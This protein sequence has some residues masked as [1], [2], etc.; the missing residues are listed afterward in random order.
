MG[1]EGSRKQL[2]LSPI[3]DDVVESEI[4]KVVGESLQR[5]KGWRCE[6]MVALCGSLRRT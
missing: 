5:M 4:D 6:A 3:F 2:V 1:F